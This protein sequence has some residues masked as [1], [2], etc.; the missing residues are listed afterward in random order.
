MPDDQRLVLSISQ[1]N[2]EVSQLLGQGF[3]SL[4]IEGEISNLAR[5]RSGHLYFSLKDDKAQVRCAMFRNRAMY[6]KVNA[7]NGMKVIAKGKV[8]LYEPRGDYQF[9][10]DQLE[11]AGEGE[12]Q[13]R[14][15]ALKKQLAERGWFDESSKQTL[16]TFPKH[17]GVITSPSGA[18]I[19]D[20]LNVLR[21]RCPQIPVRV[22][23]VAVQGDAAKEQVA[24]AIR[25]ANNDADCD[26]LIV[27][28]GGGSIEDLW[29]FNEE[30][31]A[32]AI[33]DSALPI[34]SGVGHEIDFTIADFVADKRAPTPSAAAELISPDMPAL[35]TQLQRLSERLHRLG[36]HTIRTEQERLHRLQQR[37]QLQH[38]QQQL[39][40][41]A[42]RLDDV[43]LRL[44]TLMQ[45]Q[46]R[47]QSERWQRAKLRLNNQA[48]Q[49]SIDAYTQQIHH[50][51]TQLQST[52][53]HRLQQQQDALTLHVAK[54][55]AFS[56][57]NTLE[58]G[59][60]LARDKNKRLIKSVKQVKLGQ[61]ISTQVA[62][63]QIDCVVENIQPKL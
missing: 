16:P 36:Q 19:R 26:I 1:L 29:A 9:V 2:A 30:I 60:S 10:V 59:Y 14:F 38:P 7:D 50:L 44:Q 13:R 45:H 41:K 22:Y 40:Q 18:A 6:S 62:D 8:A 58:R 57:L 47:G 27:A 15:E 53:K 17:I 34:I 5:P 11:D 25:Q 49:A 43:D 35:A 28:R 32:Q 20:I 37:L 63:G 54:L 39:Q 52:I 42:Q 4:W 61:V 21:R 31:V 12:L 51:H 55:N 23:P 24:A 33:H 3:A 48:P 46:L 56:P